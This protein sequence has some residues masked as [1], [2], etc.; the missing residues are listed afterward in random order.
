V[1]PTGIQ[2]NMTRPSIV[3]GIKEEVDDEDLESYFSTFGNVKQVKS[4]VD[5]ITE[6][7]KGFAFV[8]FDD[9][10][11]VHKCIL[12]RNDQIKGQL[13]DVKT[14]VNRRESIFG[15]RTISQPRNSGKVNSNYG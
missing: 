9:F 3:G 14:A 1:V 10:Y 6:R 11:P 8:E 7:K 2:E 15:P 5:R 12:Q 13:V 4:L